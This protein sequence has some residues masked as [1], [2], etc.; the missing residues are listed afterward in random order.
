[1]HLLECLVHA[2]DISNPCKPRPIML[3]WTNRVVQEFWAQGDEEMRL[4][5]EV[6]PMCDRASGTLAVPKGQLG[7]IDFVIMPFFTP[8]AALI[9]EAKA[10][11]DALEDNRAFWKSMEEKQAS[12]S[13]IFGEG[14]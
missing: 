2:A 4:G 11:K 10:A 8:I 9:P 6:S 14:A 7:F 3:Q 5:V 1:M 12:I 13:Q